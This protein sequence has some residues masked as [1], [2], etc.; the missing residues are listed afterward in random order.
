MKVLIVP[1]SDLT[2]YPTEISLQENT[3]AKVGELIK[4]QGEYYQ[5][6]KVIQPERLNIFWEFL[7]KLL[8]SVGC[9]LAVGVC[10]IVVLITLIY[11]AHGIQFVFNLVFN[12]L[13]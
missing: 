13:R 8:F 2:S 12:L 4:L 7:L 11:V 3:P 10:W 5:V 6:V 9:I 1:V